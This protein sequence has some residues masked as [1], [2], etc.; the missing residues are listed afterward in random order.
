MQPIEILLV[1]DRLGDAKLTEKWFRDSES[2]RDVSVVF[3][4]EAALESPRRRHRLGEQQFDLV[5]LDVHLPGI[6]GLDVAPLKADPALTRP[7]VVVLTG[8]TSTLDIERAQQQQ[9]NLCINRPADADGFN[10]MVERI[11]QLWRQF[12]SSSSDS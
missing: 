1:E 11:E 3:S 10:E 12:T 5:L 8:S 4:G 7:P 2:M 9:D 6:S